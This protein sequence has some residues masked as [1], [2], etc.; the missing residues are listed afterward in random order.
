MTRPTIIARAVRAAYIQTYRQVG[1][2]GV[3]WFHNWNWGVML[4][5]LKDRGARLRIHE[6]SKDDKYNSVLPNQDEVK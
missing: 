3:H 1:I 6:P 2:D 5:R 4:Q